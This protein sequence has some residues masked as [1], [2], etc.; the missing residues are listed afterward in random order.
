MTGSWQEI[1]AAGMSGMGRPLD[2]DQISCFALFV[3]EL[4][5]WNKRINLTAITSDREIVVKHLLDSLTLTSILPSTGRL[6]DIGSGGGFPA[7]PLA[8]VLP[9]LSITSVDAVGKKITFQRHIGRLLSLTNL[10][11][12]HARAE[13]LADSDP[14]GFDWIVSRAFSSIPLFARLA[15]PV[16]KQDGTIVAMKGRDGEQEAA[17][18]ESELAE[19]GLRVDR[20]NTLH[21]PGDNATRTLVLIRK[22][23][24]GRP[25]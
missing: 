20:V 22:D 3:D 6:L 2:A 10:T 12:I 8:I 7:I 4:K 1:L 24:K 17:A 16:L 5:R 21:L 11:A 18:A 15:L 19:M 13:T 25:S 23:G 9:G 14:G